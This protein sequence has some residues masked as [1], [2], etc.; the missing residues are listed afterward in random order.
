MNRRLWTTFPALALAALLL[1]TASALAHP[2]GGGRGGG[3]RWRQTQD[4]QAPGPGYRSCP[5][6]PR[7]QNCLWGNTPQGPRGRGTRGYTPTPPASPPAV[8][9]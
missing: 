3:P 5:N 2:W 6:Y 7:H 8:N 1:L 4:A 9:P